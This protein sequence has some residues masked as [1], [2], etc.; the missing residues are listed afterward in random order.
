MVCSIFMRPFSWMHVAAIECCR[1]G[2][3]VDVVECFPN[4]L[5]QVPKP[6]PAPPTGSYVY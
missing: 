6:G 5:A 3:G 1:A 2:A 4:D